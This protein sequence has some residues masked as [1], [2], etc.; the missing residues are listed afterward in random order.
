MRTALH[1]TL[2][3]PSIITHKIWI[4]CHTGN[5]YSFDPSIK[6]LIYQLTL[7]N[8][9]KTGE[10]IVATLK[11]FNKIRL[12]QNFPPLKVLTKFRILFPG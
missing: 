3:L 10:G 12:N 8:F 1:L 11:L 5:L 2:S 7:K 9:L 6:Y 4:K